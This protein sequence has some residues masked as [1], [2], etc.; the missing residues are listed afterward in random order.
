MSGGVSAMGAGFAS[1]LRLSLL[2][3]F[4]KRNRANAVI[5]KDENS[6]YKLAIGYVGF[7]E[8]IGQFGEIKTARKD[9]DNRHKDIGYQ[10]ADDGVEGG[11]DNDANRQIDHITP[12][13][14]FSKFF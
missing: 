3:P 8:R 2:I 11:A 14:K 10:R 4:T 5:M 13:R 6:L 9:T 12:K 1:S 7:T